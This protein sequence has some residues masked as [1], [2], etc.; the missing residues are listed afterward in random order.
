MPVPSQDHY[1]FPVFWLLTDFVCLYTYEFWLSLLEDCSEFG[2]FVITLFVNC[3]KTM[4][5]DIQTRVIK[6]E[7]IS[8]MF[9]NTRGTVKCVP[10]QPS[11]LCYQRDCQWCPLSALLFVLSEGLSMVSLI[12]PPV[13]AIRGTVKGV[14][15]QP[16]WLCYQ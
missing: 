1:V 11:C 6:N 10:C 4:Y 5:T 12:S 7:W 2:N 8:E 9:K 13:C 3:V 14:P 16:S 15:C